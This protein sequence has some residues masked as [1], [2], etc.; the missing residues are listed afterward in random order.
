MST[1]GSSFVIEKPFHFEHYDGDGM[2]E[3][4]HAPE[5]YSCFAD[6]GI[7]RGQ[8]LQQEG[9]SESRAD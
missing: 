5:A 6:G 3:C 2:S 1:F 8:V 7:R 4:T 9:F